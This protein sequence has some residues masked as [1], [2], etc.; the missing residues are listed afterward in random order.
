MLTPA[1]TSCSQNI[2]ESLKIFDVWSGVK[3]CMQSFLFCCENNVHVGVTGNIFSCPPAALWP[4]ILRLTVSD[5]QKWYLL[6]DKMQKECI[7]ISHAP[8]RSISEAF[9]LQQA[10]GSLNRKFWLVSRFK[11]IAPRGSYLLKSKAV[12]FLHRTTA[13]TPAITALREAHMC[14]I[15]RQDQTDPC[16]NTANM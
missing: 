12:G 6:I 3:K 14:E 5:S 2:G 10:S 15:T 4:L 16:R 13:A 8:C 7:R 9:V 1:S 11:A